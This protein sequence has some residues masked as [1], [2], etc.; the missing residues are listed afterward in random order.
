MS[1]H[2]LS[3]SVNHG[4]PEIAATSKP[5]EFNGANVVKAR[6]AGSPAKPSERAPRRRLKSLLPCTPKTYRR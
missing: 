5:A 3:A 4:K 1:N 6:A 2:A